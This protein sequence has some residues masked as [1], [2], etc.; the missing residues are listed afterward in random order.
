MN[1]SLG[2]IWAAKA[3][4]VGLPPSNLEGTY[5]SMDTLLS[6][7]HIN[8]NGWRLQSA[9]FVVNTDAKGTIIP[10]EGASPGGSSVV[11]HNKVVTRRRK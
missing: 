4:G 2:M 3:H 11:R 5:E 9:A 6:R 10:S 7:R 1:V 8:K